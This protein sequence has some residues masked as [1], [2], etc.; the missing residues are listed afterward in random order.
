MEVLAAERITRE[1]QHDLHHIML[2][3]KEIQNIIA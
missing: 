2:G 1:L 3:R